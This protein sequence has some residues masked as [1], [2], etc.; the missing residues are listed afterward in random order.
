MSDGLLG[1]EARP[2]RGQEASRLRDIGVVVVYSTNTEQR[3]PVRSKTEIAMAHL[4]LAVQSV[5]R[6]YRGGHRALSDINL[7]LRPGVLG[8]LGPNGAGKSTLMRI[9]ATLDSPTSGSV[10]WDG[11]DIA[12]QPNPLRAVLGYLP[13]D[14]GV[15][16]A[17]DAREFL[18]FL[19]AVKGLSGKQARLRV[20]ACLDMV[21]LADTGDRRLGQFS[22]GM[23]QRAMIAMALS[24]DPDLLIAD[25]PTTALD[26]TIQAEILELLREL[27]TDA[28]MSLV[29]ITHDLAVLSQI[30]TH[31]VVLAHGKVVEAGPVAQLLSDPQNA[32]TQGL[33][34]DATATLWRPE[35]GARA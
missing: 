10:S 14:F 17:L 22:G 21:G 1:R 26:V 12:V 27:V 23:R 5:S 34:R 33:L 2:R 11:G 24:C 13:Q 9:L 16:E 3:R 19:A 35:G 29:F 30:A 32:V 20:D 15:Y 4:Q 6:T 7:D 31:G 28:G 8:L 18:G 25:E